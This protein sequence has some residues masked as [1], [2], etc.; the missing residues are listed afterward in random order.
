MRSALIVA[1]RFHSQHRV[2]VPANP[3]RCSLRWPMV[4][5]VASTATRRLVSP[6]NGCTVRL[7]GPYVASNK[8]GRAGQTPTAGR[9]ARSH[10]CGRHQTHHATEYNCIGPVNGRDHLARAVEITCTAVSSTIITARPC[11]TRRDATSLS[12]RLTSLTGRE[13]H[14]TKIRGSLPSATT[15]AVRGCAGAGR[16]GYSSRSTGAEEWRP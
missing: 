5:S 3:S 1:G 2:D 15:V 8:P 11:R 4:A 7:V 12:V 9:G 16:R 14:G 6:G 13:R 10:R